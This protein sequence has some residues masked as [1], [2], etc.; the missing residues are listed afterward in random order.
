MDPSSSLFGITFCIELSL[1]VRL[2]SVRFVS[3]CSI[4]RQ[5]FLRFVD[6][7]CSSKVFWPTDERYWKMSGL[8]HFLNHCTYDALFWKAI[9]GTTMRWRKMFNGPIKCEGI[10][11]SF[12]SDSNP[13]NMYLDWKKVVK[14]TECW[15]TS[16]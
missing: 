16:N 11:D 6:E 8:N 10:N 2:P 7:N 5:Q 14:L 4:Y 13:F 9:T 3:L 15:R 1:P 12:K